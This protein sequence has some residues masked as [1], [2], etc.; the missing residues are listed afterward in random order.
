MNFLLNPGTAATKDL[1]LL[2]L[3]VAFGIIW[4]THGVPK[5]MSGPK[6]WLWL[7]GAMQNF[8]ITFAPLFWG[9]MA[10]LSESCG[11]ALLILG[12]ATRP[13]AFFISCV[14]FVALVMHHNKG[15]GWSVMEYP[16]SLFVIAVSFMI[17]GAGAYSFDAFLTR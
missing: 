5:I 12:L 3:R 6:T 10:S 1:A 8:G 7:G 14:M 16:F 15:D 17:A 9:L 11:G 4:M 2:F 13:A